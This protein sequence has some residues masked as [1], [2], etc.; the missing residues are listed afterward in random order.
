MPTF[1]GI[2]IDPADPRLQGFPTRVNNGAVVVDFTRP[3]SDLA[4]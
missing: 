3:I 1:D 2:P 4:S